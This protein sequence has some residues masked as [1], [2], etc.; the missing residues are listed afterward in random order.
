V[1]I[2]ST[3]YQNWRLDGAYVALAVLGIFLLYQLT[4]S[5]EVSILAI[6]CKV[7]AGYSPHFKMGEEKWSCRKLQ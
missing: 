6:T 7:G 5:L 3:V 2:F 1:V 4:L